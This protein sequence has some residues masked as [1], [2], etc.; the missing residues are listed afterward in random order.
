MTNPAVTAALVSPIAN[1]S[2][3]DRWS[4][5]HRLQ[6]LEINCWCAP[7][8]SLWVEIETGLHAILLRSVIYQWITPKQDVIDWLDRCWGF[9][10]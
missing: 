9:L 4:V 6:E 7:D 10:A 3:V 2:R 8:G 1:L 5:H